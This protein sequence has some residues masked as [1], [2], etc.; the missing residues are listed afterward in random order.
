MPNASCWVWTG[1][2]VHIW[3][4]WLTQLDICK[5]YYMINFPECK[6]AIEK[7][8]GRKSSNWCHFISVDKIDENEKSLKKDW[9]KLHKYRAVNLLPSETIE[10]RVFVNS[11]NCSLTLWRI[12]FVMALVS[13][14]KET[15][16]KELCYDSFI[17]WIDNKKDLFPSLVSLLKIKEEPE[18][19]VFDST[20]SGVCG[21]LVQEMRTNQSNTYARYDAEQRSQGNTF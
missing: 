19:P 14:V 15:T 12:E 7:M 6:T 20:L 17:K 9:N 16:Q 21:T 4:Q 10:I 11:K 13:F 3:K 18:E 1:L 2:H 8:A 5:I